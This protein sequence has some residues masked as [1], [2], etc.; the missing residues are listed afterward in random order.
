MPELKDLTGKCFGR[1]RVLRRDPDYIT[2]SGFKFTAWACECSCGTKRTVLANALLSGRSTS[3]GCYHSEK[4]K[5]VARNNFSTHKES[6]TRLYQIWNAMRERC[7]TPSASNYMNYGGRGITLCDEWN[8]YSTFREWA[9]VNS[10]TDNLSIDRIDVNSGYSP[11]NCRWV[12]RIKQANNC[13]TNRYFTIDNITKTL[14][15]WTRE[16]NMPYSLVHKRLSK[17]MDIET[18]LTKPKSINQFV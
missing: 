3:C 13:R 9:L 16:Y 2:K 4:Q 10:Y 5:D 6:K 7:N 17:G 12:D 14:A 11:N 18:A 1:W 15:E 8:D